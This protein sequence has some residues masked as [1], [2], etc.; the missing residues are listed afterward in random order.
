MNISIIDMKNQNINDVREIVDESIFAQCNNAIIHQSMPVLVNFFIDNNLTAPI[1][2]M[3]ST[4]DVNAI[5]PSAIY[6]YGIFS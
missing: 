3:V 4:V 1:P 5:K 6:G 2:C